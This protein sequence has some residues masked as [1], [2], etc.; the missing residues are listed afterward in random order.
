MNTR[1]A[2]AIALAAT[3]LLTLSACGSE[4]PDPKPPATTKPSAPSSDPVPSSE[5]TNSTQHPE[6]TG[7]AAK[8][9]GIPKKPTGKDRQNLLNALAAA[10]PDVVRYEDK[11]IDAARNQCSA[12]NGEGVKRI[13]WL[14]SQRFSYKNVTTTEAQGAKLNDALKA[15]GF[16]NV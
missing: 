2:T 10:A 8:S 12:I 16:C 3:A 15:S 4:D 14:A 5:P 7:A 9:A 1:T 6:E 13:D 11:A